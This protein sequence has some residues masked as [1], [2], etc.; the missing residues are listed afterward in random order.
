MSSLR[1]LASSSL[2]RIEDLRL[3]RHQHRREGDHGGLCFAAFRPTEIA[4]YLPNTCQNTATLAKIQVVGLRRYGAQM[5]ILKGLWW[6][7]QDSN[8]FCMFEAHHFSP[9][10]LSFQ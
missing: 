8:L 1:L 4:A 10:M 6:A 3:R 9:F 5:L 7:R 2:A